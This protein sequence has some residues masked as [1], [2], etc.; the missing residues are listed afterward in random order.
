M[1]TINRIVLAC[2]TL[3]IAPAYAKI[4]DAF[5]A[6]LTTHIENTTDAALA[7]EHWVQRLD[8]AAIELEW[9]TKRKALNDTSK[10]TRNYIEKYE[11]AVR[12]K[13]QNNSLLP[14]SSKWANPKLSRLALKH[15]ELVRSIQQMPKEL[16]LISESF[17]PEAQLRYQHHAALLEHFDIHWLDAQKEIHD[18]KIPTLHDVGF[19]ELY[20]KRSPDFAALRQGYMLNKRD[21]QA[22]ITL[23]ETNRDIDPM[24]RLEIPHN[25]E[26][27]KVSV[28]YFE[29]RKLGSSSAVFDPSLFPHSNHT[30]K[31]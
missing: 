6:D 11:R 19:N 18:L 17:L 4:T 29:Q 1:K 25:D 28:E 7:V 24:S 5:K 26:V 16:K 12:S 13:K 22:Q 31:L 20:E 9:T 2:A 21:A 10:K 3:G 27:I 8:P 15:R 30:E 14:P 23:L